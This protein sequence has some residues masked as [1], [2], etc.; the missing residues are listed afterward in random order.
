MTT[1]ITLP[2]TFQH[3]TGSIPL[4]DLDDN[5]AALAAAGGGGATLALD[6][7]HPGTFPPTGASFDAGH[8]T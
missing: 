4:K 2:Y 6:G 3:M 7:G 1:P 5:F 8:V